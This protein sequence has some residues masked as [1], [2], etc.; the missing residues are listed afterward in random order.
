MQVK[1]PLFLAMRDQIYIQKVLE[2]WITEALI[3]IS[4]LQQES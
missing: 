2:S 1:Q 3:Q 4:N